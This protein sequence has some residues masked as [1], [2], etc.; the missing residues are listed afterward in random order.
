MLPKAEVVELDMAV[1]DG[2]KMIISGGAVV[3]PWPAPGTPEGPRGEASAAPRRPVP[4]QTLTT[5]AF[6]IEKRPPRTRSR[7]SLLFSAEHGNLT[8]LQ[9][10]P[11][12]SRPRGARPLRRGLRDPRDLQP[13]AHLVRRGRRGCSP[14]A[15]RSGAATTPCASPP[16][17]PPSWP[18]PRARGEP[19]PGVA[20]CC[21]TALDAFGSAAAGHRPP[22]E[23]LLSSR[24]TRATP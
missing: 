18:Q 5:E 9:R 4:G 24:A 17:S 12:G 16:P 19:G 21:A 1:G 22:E 7:P 23:P 6:V 10:L 14:A 11:E 8:A 20:R 15:T 3:P 2:M 13:G